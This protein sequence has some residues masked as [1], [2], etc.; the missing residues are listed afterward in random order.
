MGKGTLSGRLY[1]PADYHRQGDSGG[2][3]GLYS[4]KRVI[5]VAG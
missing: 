2:R 1:R 4:I 5:A 3:R